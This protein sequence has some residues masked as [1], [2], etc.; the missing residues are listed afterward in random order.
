M[1]IYDWITSLVLLPYFLLIAAAALIELRWRRKDKW[2]EIESQRQSTTGYYLGSFGYFY[3]R[4]L[5]STALYFV[6]ITLMS[7]YLISAKIRQAGSFQEVLQHWAM[8]I[9]PAALFLVVPIFFIINLMG[10]KTGSSFFTYP[11]YA[12]SSEKLYYRFFLQWHSLDWSDVIRIEPVTIY[13]GTIGYWIIANRLP[14][15][16]R[17]YHSYDYSW[18]IR[19][20]TPYSIYLPCLLPNSLELKAKV[21]NRLATQQ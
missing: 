12:V 8:S 19:K 7:L 11:E 17:F 21:E 10:K 13:T 6:P 9:V 14:G 1:E 15:L 5:M 16:P 18:A 20:P 2:R 4:W 3:Y